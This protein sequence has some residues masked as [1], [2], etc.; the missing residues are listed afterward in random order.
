MAIY[1]KF[2][3][4]AYLPFVLAG[5]AGLGQTAPA[6]ATGPTFD[7]VSI[8]V[9]AAS[10]D[11]HNH[12]YNDP[13][14]SH[15]RVVNLSLRALLEFAYGL[16]RKQILGGPAW[17]DSTMFDMDAKSDASVDAQ[18]HAL[19]AELARHQK[20]LMVQSLLAERFGLAAHQETRELPIFG[21][22]IAKG[23][24]KFK[25]ED[26]GTTIDPGRSRLHVAGSDD[27]LGLLAR[28]LAQVLGRVVVNRT[29]LTGRYDL[30]LRW[31]PDDSPP[32]MLNGAP[33]PNAPPQIFTAIQEQLG[34]KLEPGTGPVNV[35][36]IDRIAMP[37][38]N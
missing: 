25:P 3:L 31:T 9:N 26:N 1:R 34:L 35:L 13:S 20:Q 24:P 6:S 15:F 36:V 16:P 33:D 14:E 22:V 21:L 10:T 30:T 18:L 11:G 5:L 23:G 8:H 19:P 12:I 32:A 29:G 2:F 27:T 37:S 17:L 28:E 7:V 38:E 4:G